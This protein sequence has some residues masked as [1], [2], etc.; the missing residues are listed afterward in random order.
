MANPHPIPVLY[1]QEPFHAK[2]A[3]N[4]GMRGA[5]AGGIA[6]ICAS[7]V[8]NSLAKSNIGAWGVFTRTGST[9]ATLTVVPAVYAFAK[10]ATANLRE[11]DDYLNTTV[12]AFLGGAMLGLRSGRMPQII[13]FGAGISA[14]MTTLDF[15]GGSL[16]GPPQDP[17]IDEY[18]RKEFMR[19]NRRRPMMETV[20]ELGEGRGIEPPGYE[21]RRRARLKEKYGVDINPVS[22]TADE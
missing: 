3:L 18:A 4:S 19:K 7:A 21:E 2:N 17:E 5:L 10:D 12:G 16:R 20:A 9:V 11:K 8:Q 14:I 6:G 22:A 15:T 1:P 13:G